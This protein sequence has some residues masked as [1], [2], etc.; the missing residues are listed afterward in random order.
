MRYGTK[1]AK[2]K[3]SYIALAAVNREAKRDEAAGSAEAGKTLGAVACGS[4]KSAA[5]LSRSSIPKGNLG[6]VEFP[7]P[8]YEDG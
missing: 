1:K 2:R 7:E 6:R 5:P 4:D 3:T 8:E